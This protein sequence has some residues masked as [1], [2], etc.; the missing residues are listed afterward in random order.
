MA[1]PQIDLIPDPP[2]P[3]DAEAV[4][5]TK[6]GA[7]LTAQQVMVSQ[8]NSAILWMNSQSIAPGLPVITGNAGKALTVTA[9]GLSLEWKDAGQKVGDTLMTARIP[10]ES[11]LPATGGTYL[12]SAYPAL[13]SLVGL[14]GGNL[15]TLYAAVST[16]TSSF[17]GNAIR[18]ILPGANGVWIAVGDGGKLSRSVDDGVTWTALT[19]GLG[20]IALSGIGW[21]GNQTWM[22]CG[23][24]GA[25]AKSTD[26][27]ATW[28]SLGAV[29]AIT[30]DPLKGIAL[31]GDGVVCAASTT[32]R[33]YRNTAYGVGAWTTNTANVGLTGYLD[34]VSDMKN[35]FVTVTLGVSSSYVSSRTSKDKGVTWV[36]SATL[37][38]ND[39][40]SYRSVATDFQGGWVI[41]GDKGYLAYSSDNAS[42]WAQITSN[43]TAS[44]TISAVGSDGLG[45][46]IALGY[47]TSGGAAI[48][49][50]SPPG[51]IAFSVR[52]TP[53]G[54]VSANPVAMGVRSNGTIVVGNTGANA[55][56]SLPFYTFDKNTQFKVPLL[57]IYQGLKSYI[58]AKEAA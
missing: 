28:T 51:P 4:F 13:F 42:T 2:L 26:N 40:T 37:P 33:I 50:I 45:N 55:A 14:I 36:G 30:T 23:A 53:T 34:I 9:D 24:S 27:G 41:G 3:T 15:G 39:G 6:A 48:Q 5:D 38:L 35:V 16:L 43:F 58:K 46:W 25:I 31:T 1:V 32:G 10:D 52:A 47:V 12:Q 19:S 29:T 22:I 17:A 7:S 44:D 18:K 11:Y 20:A 56:R 8:I 57:P 21:D 49:T 54:T